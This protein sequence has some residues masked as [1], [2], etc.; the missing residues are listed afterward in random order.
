MI[1]NIFYAIMYFMD[2]KQIL[3]LLRELGDELGIEIKGQR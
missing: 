3:A 1:T 2:K